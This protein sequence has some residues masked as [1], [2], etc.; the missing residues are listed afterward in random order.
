[1]NELRHVLPAN[2]ELLKIC[3]NKKLLNRHSSALYSRQ[4]YLNTW[5]LVVQLENKFEIQKNII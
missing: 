4:E 2:L 3:H 1:M 5:S